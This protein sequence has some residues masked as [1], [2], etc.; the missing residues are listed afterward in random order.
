MNN[1][2]FDRRTFMIGMGAFALV[3][4]VKFN[5][6]PFKLGVASGDPLP[7][8]IVLWT[9]L[10]PDPVNGGGVPANAV[11]VKWEIA[12]DEKLKKVVKKGEAVARPEFA[13][14]VHVEVY[15]LKPGRH[16]WYRFMTGDD[17]SPVGRTRTA[18]EFDAQL[19][20]L[21]FAFASCQHYESGY[22]TAYKHMADEDLDLVVHLGDYI[23]EGGITEGRTRRH[24]S[25][26]I[27]SLDDYRNRYG[28]YKSDEHLKAAHAMFP[29]VVTTDDHEVENNYANEISEKGMDPKEFLKMRAAAYQAYYEHMPLRRSSMPDGP[30]MKLYR[31]FTFGDLAKF[32][33]LDTRQYRTDQ[34]CGDG[35]KP[36]CDGVFDPKATLM[37]KEQEKWLFNGLSKSK[38]KWNIIAQQVMFATFDLAPG[39]EEKYSMDKWAAYDAEFKRMQEFLHERKPSNPVILTGDIHCNW[40]AD[41]KLDFNEPT[42]PVIATEFVGTSISS[43]GN[44]QDM[45]PSTEKALP[46]NPHIKYFND[47][48]GYVRCKLTRKQWVTDF[49]TVDVVTEQNYPV[50][51][52]AT[53]VVE[54]GKPGAQET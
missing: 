1:N 45:R 52:K 5:D 41:V 17:V 28:L 8:G 22:Y 26:K 27:V 48:R 49:R 33:V 39:P 31:N 32:S 53:Y 30:D 23:Y 14:S 11:K 20:H 36:N 7:N 29:W 21:T 54:D 50:T 24:N 10:A 4:P 2:N 35:A 38:S 25:K 51:T 6:N 42:S 12:E 40:V 46:E 19:D 16:Y 37:G 47:R 3:S 15:G 18:P 43:G 34:P 9:R 13:H 44:G